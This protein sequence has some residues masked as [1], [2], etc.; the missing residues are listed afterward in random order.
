MT[1]VE[2][3]VAF[4]RAARRLGASEVVL[5]AVDE[6][7]DV[8]VLLDRTRFAQVGELWPLVLAL[9]DG[10]AQ[11]RQRDDR[12]VEFLGECLEAA[13][14]LRDLLHAVVLAVAARRREE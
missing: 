9:L 14:Y 2:L 13:C 1:L 3:L 5:L 6:H 8:G 7:D 12:D 10:A 11:L 4:L